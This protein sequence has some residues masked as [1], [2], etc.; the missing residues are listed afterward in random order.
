MGLDVERQGRGASVQIK[1]SG[2]GWAPRSLCAR[3]AK[4]CGVS[5][6]PR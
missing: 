6:K 4:R 3:R 2:A 1:V 5:C